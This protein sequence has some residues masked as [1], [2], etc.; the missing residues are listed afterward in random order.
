MLPAKL[1]YIPFSESLRLE[2]TPLDIYVLV[3]VMGVTEFNVIR[4]STPFALRQGSFHAPPPSYVR[5][6]AQGKAPPL[7]TKTDVS[8]EQVVCDV[9]RGRS[10][11][12]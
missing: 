11:K 7:V 9:L 6:F 5:D 2:L 8:A 4:N 12:V 1:P 3:T 10:S